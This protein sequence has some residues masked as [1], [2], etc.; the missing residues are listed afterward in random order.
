MQVPHKAKGDE[1][2]KS[3]LNVEFRRK[4]DFLPSKYPLNTKKS[5]YLLLNQVFITFIIKIV[6]KD[7]LPIMGGNPGKW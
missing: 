4:I 5:L 1:V 6:T 2:R 3:T 7:K